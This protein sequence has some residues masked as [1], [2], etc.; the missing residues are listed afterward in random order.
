MSDVPL[1]RLFRHYSELPYSLRVLYTATLLVLGLGYLFALIYLFHVYSGRDGNPMTLSY[2]DLVIAYSGSGKHS[3]LESALPPAEAGR[4][5]A[6]SSF[7]LLNFDEL[8]SPQLRVDPA[9]AGLLDQLQRA[10]NTALLDEAVVMPQVV[11]GLATLVNNNLGLAEMRLQ[12][13][14]EDLG[15]IELRVRTSEGVVRGEMLVHNPEVKHL[16]DAQLDRL[17]AA[18]GQQGLE[19]GGFEI[20]LADRGPYPDQGRRERHSRPARPA[21]DPAAEVS[22]VAGSLRSGHAVDYLV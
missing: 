8:L 3:R 22:R 6:H 2:Q 20:G 21:P 15:E 19:L 13:Q 7:D 11:R 10:V 9:P 12:L 5:A 17:R 1:H 18:L 16:L 4:P 14:P